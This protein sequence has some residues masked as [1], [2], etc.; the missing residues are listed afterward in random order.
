MSASL[1]VALTAPPEWH[2][3]A[4]AATAGWPAGVALQVSETPQ[5]LA[6][7]AVVVA[8]AGAS[9]PPA[10]FTH[11]PSPGRANATIVGPAPMR[12]GTFTEWA[13]AIVLGTGNPLLGDA[14]GWVVPAIVDEFELPHDLRA[15]H[16]ARGAVRAIAGSSSRLDDLL[17]AASELTANAIQHGGGADHLSAVRG[18]TTITIAVTDHRPDALPSVQRLRGAA[19]S[20]RGMA[21]V[22]AISDHW[23]VTVYADRKV[24]WCG[25]SSAPASS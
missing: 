5:D 17:L 23:G 19:S 4:N 24:V 14:L 16:H 11:V 20:G 7:A 3:Q 8:V 22:D 18:V 2:E 10:Q 21:I 1:T 6:E 13:Q 9:A 15:S 25:F 12:S